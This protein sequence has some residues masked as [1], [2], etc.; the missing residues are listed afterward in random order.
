MEYTLERHTIKT[1]TRSLITEKLPKAS[2]QGP[3]LTQKNKSVML[4]GLIQGQLAAGN[5]L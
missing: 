3:H 1:V 2:G 4:T 5:N